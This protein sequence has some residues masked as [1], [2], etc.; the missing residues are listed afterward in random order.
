M[1]SL[2]LPLRLDNPLNQRTSWQLRARRAHNER[3]IT[4]LA[5]G[6][7]IRGLGPPPYTVKL[8]RFGRQKM[9]DDGLSAS[10]KHVRDGVADALKLDDGDSRFSWIYQ[11]A[12]VPYEVLI[13]IATMS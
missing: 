12:I 11:Q 7:K 5:L 8:T 1:I 3:G 2:R 9:D 6:P 13:E 4:R 10:F